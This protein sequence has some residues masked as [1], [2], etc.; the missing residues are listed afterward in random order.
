MGDLNSAG[1]GMALA[2]VP[3]LLFPI[4]GQ[5]GAEPRS[6]TEGEKAFLISHQLGARGVFAA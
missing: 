1:T 6:D 3:D 5:P 4:R 2:L